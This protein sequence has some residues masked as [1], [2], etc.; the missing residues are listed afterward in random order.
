MSAQRLLNRAMI[1][2]AALTSCVVVASAP[3]VAKS[4]DSGQNVIAVSGIVSGNVQQ[5]GFRAMIQKQAIKYN[6]AGSA[7]NKKDKTVQFSLQGEKDR[8]NQAI[9]VIRDGTKK[10]S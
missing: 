9:A 4:N 8:V 2:V 7:K 1:G 10:S 6:L 3:F 5:V